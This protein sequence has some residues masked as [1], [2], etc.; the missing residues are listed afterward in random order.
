MWTGERRRGLRRVAVVAAVML[1]GMTLNVPAAS[2]D[3]GK[4]E[5]ASLVVLGDSYASGVGNAPYLAPALPCKR[6]PL[7]YG[8]LLAKTFSLQLDFV[9][10][11]GATTAS[12]L[13]DP[14]GGE[15]QIDS[16]TKSTDVVTVQAL[17][18]D[19]FAS[20][21][22]ALCI[23]ADCSP[24]AVLPPSSDYP[25]GTTVQ[26]VL[27]AI[28]VRSPALLDKL[29]DAIKKR[30]GRNTLVVVVGYPDPFPAPSGAVGQFCPFMTTTELGVAQNFVNAVDKQIKKAARAH[31]FEYVSV[32]SQFD[33]HDIC[34]TSPAIYTLGPIA[35]PTADPQGVLHPTAAGQQIYARAIGAQLRQVRDR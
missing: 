8:P 30:A 9:A 20:D 26:D 2:A 19:F 5:R 35:P 10:C 13:L 3:P 34:G 4:G 6:S 15:P 12:I 27:N 16:V 22:E 31:G 28:P 32:K 33:G 1:G 14:L 7:A 21:L 11:S 24:S 25:L 18:N 23:L 17:G 29:Y